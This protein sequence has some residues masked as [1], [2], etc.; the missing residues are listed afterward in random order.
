MC[1]E[2]WFYGAP[3]WRALA[4]LPC[5]SRLRPC[6]LAS[7]GSHLL[8]GPNPSGSAMPTRPYGP[9]AYPQLLPAPW[10]RARQAGGGGRGGAA[11]HLSVVGG[12]WRP[13]GP[14]SALATPHAA[15]RPAFTQRCAA[16]PWVGAGDSLFEVSCLKKELAFLPPIWGQA[17]FRL[18]R[19]RSLLSYQS[20]ILPYLSTRSLG[21]GLQ[22][23]ALCRRLDTCNDSDRRTKIESSTRV[24]FTLTHHPNS[25]VHVFCLF[26]P[27]HCIS[28]LSLTQSMRF[29][30]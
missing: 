5:G 16:V 4:G 17:G 29:G 9:W 7:A 14:P 1:Y 13:L 25:P 28:H 12:A 26:G 27:A 15:A 18:L 2:G 24:L 19:P 23:S 30:G 6:H 11:A 22:A 20:P 8:P 21:L 3:L 10:V